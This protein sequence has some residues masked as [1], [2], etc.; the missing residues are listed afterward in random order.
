[1][2]DFVRICLGACVVKSSQQLPAELVA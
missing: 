1:M 2:F